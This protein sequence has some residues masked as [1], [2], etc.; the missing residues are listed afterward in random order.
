MDFKENCNMTA[1]RKR[2][3]TH[4]G[5]TQ[6]TWIVDYRDLGGR[7][8]HRT[9]GTRKE[10]NDFAATTHIDLKRGIHIPD[11]ESVTVAAAGMLWLLTNDEDELETYSI[12]RNRQHLNSHIIPRIGT[13]RLNQLNVGE[14]RNFITRMR[15][16]GVSPALAKMIVTSLG[17]I[18]ADAQERGLASHN[19]VREMR[20][21][22]GKRGK[23]AKDR[24]KQRL[25]MGVDIPKVS[26]IRSILAKATGRRRAII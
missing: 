24:E 4:N 25:E 16:E 22:R 20:T 7:R 21:N 15:S 12:K 5:E 8:R 17:S 26:E 2:Q 10:A 23:K 19:P 1:V 11:R 3:W 14:V 6:E 13:K 18:I 9:F